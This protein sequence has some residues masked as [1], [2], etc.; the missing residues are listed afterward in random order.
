[1]RGK[2]GQHRGRAGCHG[3]MR[4]QLTQLRPAH[5][6]DVIELHI[7]Q[8]VAVEEQHAIVERCGQHADVF[9]AHERL[10][11]EGEGGVSSGGIL[12]FGRPSR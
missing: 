9:G 6:G 10:A 2:R 3:K 12:K 5:G 4:G 8:D 1:M 11:I 7:D